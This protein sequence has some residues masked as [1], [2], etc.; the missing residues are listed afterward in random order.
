MPKKANTASLPTKPS[1]QGGT[2]KKVYRRIG[3]FSNARVIDYF[4]LLLPKEWQKENFRKATNVQA[5]IERAQTDCHPDFQNFIGKE[6]GTVVGLIFSNGV[7]PKP[8]M[9]LWF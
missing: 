6:F 7:S 8:Q 4:N 3:N 2:S 9:K 1:H 5:Q